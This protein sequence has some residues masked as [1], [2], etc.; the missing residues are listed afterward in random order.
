MD[1]KKRARLE[2]AITPKGVSGHR[3]PRSLHHKPVTAPEWA[4]WPPGRMVEKWQAVSLS[5]GLDPDSLELRDGGFITAESFPGIEAQNEFTRRMDLIHGL[6]RNDCEPL[7]HFVALLGSLSMPPE[8]TALAVPSM[9]QSSDEPSPDDPIGRVDGGQDS[10]KIDGRTPPLPPFLTTTELIACFG[11]YMGV[12]NPAKVL[13]EY[14][15]WAIKDMAL[16]HKGRPGKP[17]R[18]RPDVSEWNPV[19]FALNLLDKNPLPQLDGLGDLKQQHLD[20]VFSFKSLIEWR[21][22][23]MKSKPI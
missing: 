11:G 23:W 18:E 14:P 22:L 2:A 8:L 5:L 4:Y 16:V 15:K 12:T 7:A 21:P 9:T 20:T 1:D 10:A 17:S 13:S 19:R 6:T 3:E